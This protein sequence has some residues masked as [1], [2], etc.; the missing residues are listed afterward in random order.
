MVSIGTIFSV[1]VVGAAVAGGYALYRNFDKI[2]GAFTRTTEEYLTNPLGSWLDSLSKS[3][4][5]PTVSAK[6]P[7]GGNTPFVDYNPNTNDP[8]DSRT[9]TPGYTPP[10]EKD[11][12][13]PTQQPTPYAPPTQVSPIPAPA[14][15]PAP[16]PIPKQ[17]IPQSGASYDLD[18]TKAGYYYIDYSGSKF[19]TQWLLSAFQ[20]PNVAKAAAAP[21]DALFGIKYIGQS[22]LGEAGFKLFGESQNYL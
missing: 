8:Q 22:K 1:I 5:I 13:P 14:P 21:G 2:G 19:D 16:A 10:P 3:F 11:F 20:A 6:P 4:S 7:T 9:W 12:L 18:P 15:A 17:E